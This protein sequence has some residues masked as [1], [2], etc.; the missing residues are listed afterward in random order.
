MKTVAAYEHAKPIT[1]SI[2]KLIDKTND[3]LGHVGLINAEFS[4]PRT[5]Y[6]LKVTNHPQI[7]QKEYRKEFS[8]MIVIYTKQVQLIR[9]KCTRTL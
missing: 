3:E 7:G 4:K 6:T 1:S 9:R 8:Q 5:L 2:I